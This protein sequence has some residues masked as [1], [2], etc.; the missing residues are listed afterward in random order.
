M[1]L[2]VLK[3]SNSNKKLI[4]VDHNPEV[5]QMVSNRLIVVRDGSTSSI[6]SQ[7]VNNG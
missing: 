3:N 7:E 4:V 1:A 2:E 6:T 5:K